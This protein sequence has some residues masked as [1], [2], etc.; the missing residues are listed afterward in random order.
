MKFLF[1]ALIVLLTSSPYTSKEDFRPVVVLE[2]FTSQGCSNCPPAD[3]LMTKIN[4]KYDTSQVI[5][6]SFHVD[7]WNYIGWKDPFSTSE[8]SDL[9]RSYGRKFNSSSIYTP[10]VIINGKEHMVGSNEDQLISKINSYLSTESSH[11]ISISN[12]EMSEANVLF[13]YEID[14]DLS[15][16]N[17][18]VI[19][20]IDERITSISTG[21]N[22]NRTL[23][24][25]N[26]V[27]Q[28]M[29][30]DSISTSGKGS[31]AIPGLVQNSD[32]LSLTLLVENAELDILAG[33]QLKL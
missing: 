9:Q 16:K 27:V 28:Q 7:Y 29:K 20:S 24:N 14:G 32:K 13:N 18:R 3:E 10:Q 21:E 30:I 2:L 22:K 19:L 4:K 8:F 23:K 15:N 31:I 5:A 12:A 6:L 33:T 17:L 1:I 26:I 25:S 11:K